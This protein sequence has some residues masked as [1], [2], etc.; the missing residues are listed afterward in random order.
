MFLWICMMISRLKK[1][2]K[3]GKKKT[4]VIL[5]LIMFVLLLV[6]GYFVYKTYFMEKEKSIENTKVK[7]VHSKIECLEMG[8]GPLI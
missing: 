2:K 8:W 7:E 1:G 6:G 5:V 4:I 3:N